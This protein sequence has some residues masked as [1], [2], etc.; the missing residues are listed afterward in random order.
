MRVQIDVSENK[1]GTSYPWWVI[2]DLDKFIGLESTSDVSGTITSQ[3]IAG[4]FFSRDEAE[5]AMRKHAH[6]YTGRVIILCLSGY[7]S[8]QYRK[9][10]DGEVQGLSILDDHF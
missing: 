6:N 4:P 3:A 1:E 7:R 8:E 9:R 2:V 5:T 10:L